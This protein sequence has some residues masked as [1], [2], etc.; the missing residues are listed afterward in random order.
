MKGQAY[1][2]FNKA[3]IMDNLDVALMIDAF[4]FELQSKDFFNAVNRF[5]FF[6]IGYGAF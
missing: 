1:T 2:V 5:K 6:G 3:S 4:L